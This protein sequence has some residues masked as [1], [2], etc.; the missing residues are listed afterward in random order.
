MACKRDGSTLAGRTAPRRAARGPR[1]VRDAHEPA[2]ARRLLAPHLRLRR[3]CAN[4]ERERHDRPTARDRRR[5]HRPHRTTARLEDRG[6]RATRSPRRERG[7][8]ACGLPRSRD[9]ADARARRRRQGVRL[10]CVARRRSDV[11]DRGR[12]LD[13]RLELGG[14]ARRR[15]RRSSLRSQRRD[16]RR[17][18]DPLEHEHQ[19]RGRPHALEHVALVRG[20]RQGPGARVRS[21]RANDLRS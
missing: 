15:R 1:F 9:R 8:L 20:D 7:P 3:R 4:T 14:D 6:G 12:R 13:L 11:R 5:R 17:L 18:R 10:A 19:L 16:R 21:S 2:V